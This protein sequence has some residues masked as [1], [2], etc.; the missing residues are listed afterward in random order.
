MGYPDF[1]MEQL[2]SILNNDRTFRVDE[3]L[4]LNAQNP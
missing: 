3:R 1:V 4:F 2:L